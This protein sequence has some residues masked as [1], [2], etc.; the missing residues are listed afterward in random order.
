M[1]KVFLISTTVIDFLIVLIILPTVLCV[2]SSLIT[3]DYYILLFLLIPLFF[4]IILLIYRKTMFSKIEI[5][6]VGIRRIYKNEIINSLAWDNVTIVKATNNLILNFLEK[7]KTLTEIAK[8]YKTNISFRVNSKNIK[9]IAA[10]NN[11]FKNKITDITCLPLDYQI[12][13]TSDHSNINNQ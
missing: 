8:S 1:K 9:I 6:S 12:K 5:D 11:F 2:V 10:Y 13:L 7:E 3:A 4:S